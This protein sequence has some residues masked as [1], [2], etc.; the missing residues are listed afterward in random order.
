MAKQIKGQVYE[1]LD[2][3]RLSNYKNLDPKLL[4][5]LEIIDPKNKYGVPYMWGTVGIAYNLEKVTTV[6]GENPPV[7]SWDLVFKTENMVKLKD[8]GVSFL[9]S[10]TEMLPA[11]FKFL[12]IKPDT[13]NPTKDELKKAEDLFM[14]IRPYVAYFHSSKYISDL[15]NGNICVA[16]GYSGDLYQSIARSKEAGG[17]VKLSYNIPKEGAATF[18]DILGILKDAENKENAHKYIDF[19]LQPEIMAEIINE[20]QFS[21]ANVKTHNLVKKELAD[22]PNIFPSDEILDNLYTFP[23]LPSQVQRNMNRIWTKIKSGK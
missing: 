8:C 17:K 14:Q 16:I 9:D 19:L 15:A 7:N 18:F 6:L 5:I 23:D 11:A 10:P 1:V 12:G 4:K 13:T 20:M 21:S 22:D 2:K 3:S